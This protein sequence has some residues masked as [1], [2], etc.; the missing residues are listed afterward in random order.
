[1]TDDQGKENMTSFEQ[2]SSK[3]SIGEPIAKKEIRPIAGGEPWLYTDAAELNSIGDEEVRKVVSKLE[4]MSGLGLLREE[5]LTEGFLRIYSAVDNERVPLEDVQDYL[6]KINT[7]STELKKGP[8]SVLEKIGMGA[9]K[10]E[11]L[12]S[13]FFMLDPAW[14]KRETGDISFQPWFAEAGNEEKNLYRAMALLSSAAA[15]KRLRTGSI[16]AL[17]P[18]AV[19]VEHVQFAPR[20][21]QL[22]KKDFGL[23]YQTPGVS[24]LL[25]EYARNIVFHRRIIL[26]SGED[27]GTIHECKD[28]ATLEGMRKEMTRRLR[29]GREDMNLTEEEVKIAESIAYLL[30]F[31]GNL[32][33]SADNPH[34]P[35]CRPE[36]L[37]Q[38]WLPS[39]PQIRNGRLEFPRGLKIPNGDVISVVGAAEFWRFCDPLARALEKLGQPG[40]K[41]EGWGAYQ[42]WTGMMINKGK[43]E[44]A[45]EQLKQWLPERLGISFFEEKSVIPAG[46]GRA[47]P[48]IELILKGEE[49]DLN[50]L[51]ES[52]FLLYYIKLSRIKGVFDIFQSESKIDPGL[53]GGVVG[54]EMAKTVNKVLQTAGMADNKDLVRMLILA[55]YHNNREKKIQLS[56]GGFVRIGFLEALRQAGLKTERL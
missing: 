27:L 53:T 31:N 18:S 22:T 30:I 50:S 51:P 35:P 10:E 1:M 5:I 12:N 44:V 24:W 17:I 49:I 11:F 46:G 28:Q 48:L 4:K 36:V 32:I 21:T 25:T 56:S 40:G 34:Q 47:V 26:P 42:T 8:P 6:I 2:Q 23:L 13:V 14:A 52:P 16:D 29:E 33:E 38:V 7:R 55:M 45:A 43:S 41:Q 37:A 19:D 39:D 3:G 9:S 54:Q 20:I 15:E